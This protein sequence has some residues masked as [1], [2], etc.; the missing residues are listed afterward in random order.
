MDDAVLKRIKDSM[1]MRGMTAAELSRRCGLDK[2]LISRYLS[3]KGNPKVASI[4]RISDALGVSAAWV[5]GYT[6]DMQ[7]V[8]ITPVENRLHTSGETLDLRPLSKANK[9]RIL[10][11]Y[12]ALLDTQTKIPK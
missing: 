5:L 4:K 7:A 3:G 9:I 1:K 8:P 2:G 11:Y 6:L 10:A 12:Q